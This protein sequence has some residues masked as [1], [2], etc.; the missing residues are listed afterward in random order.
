MSFKGGIEEAAKMLSGLGHEQGE[1]L[2]NIIAEKNPAMADELRTNMVT[3]EDL[4][5]LTVKMIQE[6][7]RE[8]DLKDLGLA[9]RI[10][11]TE[12][13]EHF[14]KNVSKSICQELADVL[15]GPPQAVSKV[16]ESA[17]KIL[18]LVREKIAKGEIVLNPLGEEL[19]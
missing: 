8:I 3:L 2:L 16:Q 11:S 15:Q 14:F 6:L 5:Y 18:I 13:K 12:L 1:K 7:L 4:K 9:L 10:G 19:V 17:D